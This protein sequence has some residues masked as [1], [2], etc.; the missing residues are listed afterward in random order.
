MHLIR[1]N[2]PGV[3]ITPLGQKKVAHLAI[4]LKNFRDKQ[5]NSSPER[6]EDLGN[7][8]DLKKIFL[9]ISRASISWPG[10][11]VST[12]L[13]IMATS[14]IPSPTNRNHPPPQ[15]F[16]VN[17]KILTLEKGITSLCHAS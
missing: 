2:I 3:V 13:P 12:V 1:L 7:N 9:N 17:M 11:G 10:L 4:S 16:I 5:K 14:Q 6:Q 8:Q 15:E